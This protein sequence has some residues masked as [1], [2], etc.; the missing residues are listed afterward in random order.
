[1][2][3]AG[4]WGAVLYHAPGVRCEIAIVNSGF[5]GTRLG[6]GVGG[7]IPRERV[8]KFAAGRRSVR[9]RRRARAPG[10]RWAYFLRLN[11][12][13]LIFLLS[14]LVLS[15]LFRTNLT[16]TVG[17]Y[18]DRCAAAPRAESSPELSG[19]GGLGGTSTTKVGPAWATRQNIIF[20]VS[21]VLEL[22]SP[23]SI[24][25]G[26]SPSVVP[27]IMPCWR[28]SDELVNDS[29]HIKFLWPRWELFAADRQG[30]EACA[31]PRSVP[32]LPGQV[33]CVGLA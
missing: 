5:G 18:G 30:D 22:H 13:V 25:P 16:V 12:R 29:R 17:Y 24:D 11:I 19:Q 4:I 31:N 28:C 10:V 7:A 32:W 1:M 26:S 20:V 3:T 9:R 2:G 33:L 23:Q 21:R 8:R 14:G 15:R 6:R 27:G